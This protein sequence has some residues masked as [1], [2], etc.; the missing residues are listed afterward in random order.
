M[1]TPRSLVICAFLLAAPLAF[2]RDVGP[3]G[4]GSPDKSDMANAKEAG[5]M[6]G[7][8]YSANRDILL[9]A[10]W[11]PDTEG[12]DSRPLFKAF[13]E[14]SCGTGYDAICQAVFLKDGQSLVLTVD[15]NKKYLPL[16]H[17]S[18]E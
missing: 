1:K 7:K 3:I 15:Q 16:V 6:L 13:P 5:L 18:K 2:G 14:I 17:V 11:R 12:M 10:S 8:P 9:R 4:V